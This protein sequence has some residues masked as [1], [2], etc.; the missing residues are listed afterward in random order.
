[1][2]HTPHPV[3]PSKVGILITNL[4]TPDEPTTPA[5]RRYLKEFLWDPRVVEMSRPLWWLILNGVILRVRP[6]RSAHAYQS[7]WT[8]KGSPLMLNSLLQLE[9]LQARMQ[10]VYGDDVVVELAM[11]YGNPSIEKGLAALKEKGCNRVL[12]FPLY[13][14][15][16]ASTTASTTDAVF[17][18]LKTWRNVP[19]LRT[20]RTYHDDAGYIAALKASVERHWAANGKP[21]RLLMSFHG[22]P[23]RYFKN[24]DPYPCL[25]RKTARLLAES[26]G[27]NEDQ[28]KITFQSRFGREEWVQPYTDATLKEWGAEGVGRVDV[29][30]PGFSSDC[31][32][33]LEE[34]AV[35][36][37]GYFIEAGGKDLQYIPC[38][39]GD[40]EHLDI[41][42]AMTQKH[43]AGWV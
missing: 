35:E 32:E 37:K 7:V 33:T 8:E 13:P 34:I 31:L 26:L 36:N 2:S 4:G 18:V 21:D 12:V 40:V 16:S 43:L 39:N 23:Q 19:E 41:L 3:K 6:A 9:G 15:Y 5:L 14:Q 10:A 1:M 42:A 20:V 28:W 27:L 24:G 38:L 11:R 17:D 29:I 22:I 25:C 30:C